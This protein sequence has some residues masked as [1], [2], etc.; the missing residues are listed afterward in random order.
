MKIIIDP[1]TKKKTYD[2]IDGLILSL[3]D[4]AV[5]SINYYTL[6]EIK[7]IQ[8]NNPNIE[9]FISLNK[10]FMNEELSSL[11]KILLELDKLNLSGILFYDVAV[12]QLKKKL[13]LKTDLVW[14]STYMVN[15]FKTC[16][17]YYSK[18]VK[19][20]L[21]SKEITLEEIK[22]IIKS[23][24]ITSMIEVVGLPSVSFSKR[25][26]ITNFYND[27]NKK[28]KY[29]ITIK[30]KVT[31]D[32][33]IL[34]EDNNGTNFYLDKLVNGTSII[35]E[36]FQVDCKYIILREYGIDSETFYQL[37]K[38]T[39]KYILDNCCDE[40]YIEKYKKLGNF[41]NFFFKKTIYKVKKNG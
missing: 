6:D 28:P 37:I 36:L 9:I 12:L 40:K 16:D 33:Y 22:E 17:Y 25:R 15:N 21:L 8:N 39:K 29:N 30:E 24:K 20:A 14:A 38:D 5:Q 19:Y 18:G 13:N 23:S 3:K 41:T 31:N 32:N 34:F 11:Q 1:I 4:Y 26:L 27:L 2:N 35:K 10:N 7:E